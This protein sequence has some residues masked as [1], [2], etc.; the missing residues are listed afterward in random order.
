NRA[1][2]YIDDIVIS[3]NSHEEN[4][5]KLKEVFERF[6]KYNL[7]IKPSKCHIGAGTITYLGYEISARKG[8]SPGK[9]KT[10]VI[11]NWPTPKSI[12]DIRAF[13]GLTSFFRRAIKDYSLI[14]G[15]LNKLIRKDFIAS[16]GKSEPALKLESFRDLKQALITRPCLTPVDF[17]RHFIVTCDASATHF[18]SCLSQVDKNGIEKPCGYAS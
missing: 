13:I 17:N 2:V 11:A 8:I 12:K 7:K 5:Q 16:A 18:G 1:Y 4:I 6:R 15:P 3:V 9:V 10:E 14:S